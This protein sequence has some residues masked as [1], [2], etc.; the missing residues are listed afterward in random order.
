MR[1]SERG[2][3]PSRGAEWLKRRS[4]VT[5]KERGCRRSAAAFQQ[6]AIGRAASSMSQMAESKTRSVPKAQPRWHNTKQV[7][8]YLQ[9]SVSTLERMRRERT[10]PKCYRIGKRKWAYDIASCDAWIRREVR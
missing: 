4:T 2:G 3:S 8:E 7:A 10:G 5:R 1:E 9:L 6:N